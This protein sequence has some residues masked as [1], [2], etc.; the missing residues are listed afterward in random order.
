MQV[1]FQVQTVVRAQ[2]IEPFLRFRCKT[3][4]AIS[5]LEAPVPYYQRAPLCK[6]KLFVSISSR[7]F[8][9]LFDPCLLRI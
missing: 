7:D 9:L 4:T 6:F 2:D 3:M 5:R 8:A 1:E